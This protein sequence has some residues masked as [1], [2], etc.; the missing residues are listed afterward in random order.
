MKSNDLKFEDLRVHFGTGRAYT[1]SGKG[2]D[3]VTGYRIGKKCN[4]G[5]IEVSEWIQMVRG[6]IEKT[7]EQELHQQ[8]L[9][10]MK[11]HNYTKATKSEL[12][13]EGLELH[14]AR[15]FD[16]PLWVD[17][18]PFNERFRPEVLRTVKL[19]SVMP[20]CCKKQG[21]ITDARYRERTTHEE[22]NFCPHCGRWT[23]ISLVDAET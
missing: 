14:A 18:I 9:T 2:K 6:L 23:K 5:D 19:V 10:H 16:D 15:I 4:L 20:E 21:Y 13:E 3:R 22:E 1:V 11:E 8:L 17:F 7:G 12:E